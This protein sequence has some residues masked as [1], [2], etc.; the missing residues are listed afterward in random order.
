MHDFEY[1]PD[2]LRFDEKIRVKNVDIIDGD[3]LG[4]TLPTGERCEVRLAG[5]DAPELDQPFG[6]QA[7]GHLYL[8]TGRSGYIFVRDI[9]DYGRIVAEMYCGRHQSLNLSMISAGYAYNY[10]RFIEL[11]RGKSEENVARRKRRGMWASESQLQKPWDYRAGLEN[12]PTFQNPEPVHTH[13][14]DIHPRQSTLRHQQRTEQRHVRKAR[15][16][17]EPIPQGLEQDRPF[18][19]GIRPR[20]SIP[21]RQQETERSRVKKLTISDPSTFIALVL[22][23]V[24]IFLLISSVCN[25]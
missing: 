8:I 3:S 25:D 4:V 19:E 24:L 2:D 15:P 18:T 23:V 7:R 21:R 5:I 11:H 6:A 22:A 13:I 12:K 14:E 20:Q 10:P 1:P 17:N 9:D 16:E